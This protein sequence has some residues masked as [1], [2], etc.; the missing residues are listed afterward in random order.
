MSSAGREHREQ[1]LEERWLSAFVATMG[2]LLEACRDVAGGRSELTWVDPA[3]ILEAGIEPWSELPIWLPPDH[4][5]RGMQQADVERAHASGLRC[6]PIEDTVVD[7]WD[8][9]TSVG[10]EPALRADREPPGLASV[11]EHAALAA[12]H[13]GR[14]G[15]T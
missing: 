5:F 13:A 9:L 4:E 14:P 1:A 12:W 2:K 8:W 15:P 11:K 3:N 10:M 7:T 6:R